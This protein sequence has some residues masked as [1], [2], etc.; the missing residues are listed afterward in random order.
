MGVVVVAADRNKESSVDA[1]AVTTTTKMKTKIAAGITGINA[2][3]RRPT[4]R[5]ATAATSFDHAAGMA[6]IGVPHGGGDRSERGDIA[7]APPII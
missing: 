3:K 5:P 7:L 2:G 1:A 6:G 4:S